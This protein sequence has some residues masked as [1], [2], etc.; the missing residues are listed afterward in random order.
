MTMSDMHVEIEKV[1][2]EFS[3]N[4]LDFF[5]IL[6]DSDNDNINFYKQNDKVKNIRNDDWHSLNLD[7]YDLWAIS[8]NG[9]YLW[10]NG[11][12]TI[13]MNPRSMNL[14]S[15]CISPVQFLRLAQMGNF[16][17]IFPSDLGSS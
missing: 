11:R 5:W 12:Q 15:Q 14:V 10:W 1:I 2:D 3:D 8:D 9:D 7:G 13:G 17:S 16:S 4:P 6:T